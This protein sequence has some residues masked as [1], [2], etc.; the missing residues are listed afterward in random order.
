MKPALTHRRSGGGT[1]RETEMGRWRMEIPAGPE[2]VYRLAQLD[3]H[4]D[5]PR[6][7]FAWQ[8][9]LRLELRARVSADG[10]PGTWGFGLWNDPFSA[11]IGVSGMARKLPLLPNTAWF[12]YAGEPNYL[13][14][15]DDHPAQGFL[16]A[17]FK[18]PKI[19][20]LALAP[21]VITLP[22]LALRPAARLLRR[23]ARLLVRDDA[24][25]VPGSAADWRTYRIDWR[26]E[27]VRF[28][29]NG[30]EIFVTPH[31]PRG[32]LGF[33][34]WLDNQYAA[35]PPSGRLRFGTSAN[36][37]AAWLDVEAVELSRL[38]S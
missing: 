14:L 27:G 21:G 30:Q 2:G 38:E 31:S 26:A 23:A 11:N 3:D 32:P 25:I 34:V 33:V 10:M 28:A 17:V 16:A 13:A 19:P 29:V 37:E 15:R 35:F 36:P 8:P 6:S 18:A 20:S 1:V 22:L 4:M 5:L 9:P 7:A 12:F 24:A